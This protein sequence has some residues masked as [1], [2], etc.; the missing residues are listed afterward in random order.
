MRYGVVGYGVVGQH[1]AQDVISARQYVSVYDPGYPE[2][3][4]DGARRAIN[5]CHC[6]FVCV[7]TPLEA[8]GGQ[9]DMRF[10]YD[11]FTW[12]KVPVAIIR[13]ALAIHTADNLVARGHPVVVSPE[14]IGEGVRPPYVAMSQPPFMILGGTKPDT[15]RAIQCLSRLYNSECEMITMSAKE[16]EIAKLVENYFL[17]LKVTWANE[18]YEMCR[19]HNASYDAVMGGLVHDYRIGRSHTHV[20][21]DNRGWSSK[22]LNK[23]LPGLLGQVG[24]SI[25]PLLAAVIRT[26]DWHKG[27][28]EK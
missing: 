24:A 9:L 3:S 19:F 10:V 20:Y 1:M 15:A 28:S 26:N 5:E 14:F 18:V 13:S 4:T 27:R 16:A 21:A 23:D 17:A 2:F 6:A 12:L 11:V 8:E 7:P 22:C 25:A